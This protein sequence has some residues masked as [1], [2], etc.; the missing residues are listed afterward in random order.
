MAAETAGLGLSFG[1]QLSPQAPSPLTFPAYRVL[2]TV[3]L[4]VPFTVPLAATP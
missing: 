4:T 1:D 3:L 2:L